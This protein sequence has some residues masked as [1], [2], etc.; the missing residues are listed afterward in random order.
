MLLTYINNV[1]MKLSLR[2][3]TLMVTTYIIKYGLNRWIRHD[4]QGYLNRSILT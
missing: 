1:A 3:R 4:L 2:G